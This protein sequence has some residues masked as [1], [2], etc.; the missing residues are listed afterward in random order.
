MQ[1]FSVQYLQTEFNN[2]LL[3]RS[4]T[5][6]KLVSLQEYKDGSMYTSQ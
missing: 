1:K 6:I 5:M 4:Y 2:S 3:K